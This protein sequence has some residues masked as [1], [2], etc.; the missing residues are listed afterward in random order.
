[1]AASRRL[2]SPWRASWPGACQEVR[3]REGDFVQA[4]QV[5]ARLQVEGL[6]AQHDEARARCSRR[7]PGRGQRRAGTGAQESDHQ[8]ALAQVVQRESDLQ[9]ARRRL[10]RTENWREDGFLSEQVLDDDRRQAAQR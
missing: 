10:P 9:S 7:L 6:Q 8:A 2:K 5:L 1:M 4:G 3:V